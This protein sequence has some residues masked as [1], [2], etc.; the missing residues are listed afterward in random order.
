MHGCW[1]SLPEMEIISNCYND[2]VTLM[3]LK[4]QVQCL[5]IMEYINSVFE[6]YFLNSKWLSY[7]D[8]AFSKVTIYTTAHNCG[9]TCVQDSQE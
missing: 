7:T 9:Y 3:K 2:F 5:C 8:K 1:V 4:V 6:L